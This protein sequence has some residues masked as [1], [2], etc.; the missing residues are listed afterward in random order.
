MI[1]K[2]NNKERESRK[3]KKE[4]EKYK[5][6]YKVTKQGSTVNRGLT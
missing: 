6:I 2:E 5:A 1:K 3:E 4:Y